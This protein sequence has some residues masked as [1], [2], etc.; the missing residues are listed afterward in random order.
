MRFDILTL[1]PEAFESFCTTSIIKRAIDADIIEINRYDIRD[2][3]KNK[4]RKVDDVPYGGGAG[5]L[6]MPQPLFNSI[7]HVKGLADDGAPVIFFTPSN[8]IL[9]QE[10]AESFSRGEIPEA[11]N[12]TLN[13]KINRDSTPSSS[14]YPGGENDGKINRVILL[15][16]HYEGIDQR[17]RDALVD[18]EISLGNF[19]L[20]GGELPTQIFI[21]S[22][23]RLIPGVLGKVESHEEESFSATVGRDKI[24]YPHYTRP[25]EFRGMK[26]PDVLLSGHHAKIDEWRAGNTEELTG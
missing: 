16:G 20:T 21:D 15:C 19:V 7:E 6:M 17:V 14:P 3:S 8:N 23:A 24:E 1:F 11:L 25:D 2:F 12:S 18:I 26:V 9:D 13:K 4:H 10:I 22:V 5:M